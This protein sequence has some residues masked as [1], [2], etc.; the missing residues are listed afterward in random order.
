M[1]QKRV[2][3]STIKFTTPPVIVSTGSVAGPKEGRGPLAP[4]FD[5]I[6]PDDLF[7]ERTTEKAER[8]FME[9]AAKIALKNANLTQ[10]QVDFFVAGDLLNQIVAAS[11]TAEVFGVPYVGIYGA[12]ST[13]TLG[14]TVAAVLVDGGYADRVLVATSSHYQTAERQFRYPVELNTQRKTTS[15]Y[16]VTGAGAF[17]V[18]SS[19]GKVKIT[20]ATVGTVL[21]MGIK[22]ANQMGPAMAPAA[23]DTLFRHLADTGRRPED[24]DFIFTGDLGAV[25]SNI[26][27]AL[28]KE[29]G[30]ILGDNYQDAG[31]MVFQGDPTAGAGGS[32]CACSALVLGGYVCKRMQDNEISR[33]LAIATG[34]LLSPL[35][36]QQGESIPAV[37]NAVALE[38]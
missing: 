12:C 4:W 7:G 20:E 22:D 33:A 37:A 26:F 8:R 24:Y 29:K 35:T 25:G 30:V 28:M 18:A 21:D 6:V 16:T 23:A 31:V 3:D 1:A 15:Q 32:G 19:G 36:T 13:S 11:F 9:D 2:G 38:L 10:D 14:L 27:R 34:A 17:L 5:E